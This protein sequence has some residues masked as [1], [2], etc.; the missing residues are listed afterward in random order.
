MNKTL[1]IESNN[2]SGKLLSDRNQKNAKISDTNLEEQNSHW[3]TNLNYGVK[4]EEGDQLSISS[5]QINLRGDP[6]QTIEFSA[7]RCSQYENP[8]Y[9]N[10]AQVEYAYYVT[11][12]HQFNMPLPLA[13][14]KI[15]T[16]RYWM[17]PTFG[18][19]AGE[20]THEEQEVT[21]PGET[22]SKN[23]WKNF[24]E[25][26]PCVAFE[27][28]MEKQCKYKYSKSEGFIGSFWNPINVDGGQ[29]PA[30]HTDWVPPAEAT[31][32][33]QR[34]TGLS[35]CGTNIT[36]PISNGPFNIAFP[37]NN[38]LYVCRDDHRG[39]W[40][41][42]KNSTGPNQKLNRVYYDDFMTDYT[43]LEADE[44]FYTPSALGNK[45]TTAFHQREGT[46]EDWKPVN[47]EPYVYEHSST[48]T[49]QNGDFAD[50][51]SGSYSQ[52]SHIKA[53]YLPYWSECRKGDPFIGPFVRLNKK[54]VA[55]V[56]DR[57]YKTIKTAGGRLLDKIYQA[58]DLDHIGFDYGRSEWSKPRAGHPGEYDNFGANIPN[59]KHWTWQVPDPGNTDACDGAWGEHYDSDNGRDLFYEN[60]LVGDMN[61]YQ[62]QINFNQFCFSNIFPMDFF[63]TNRHDVANFPANRPDFNDIMFGVN[64]EDPDFGGAGVYLSS[65]QVLEAPAGSYTPDSADPTTFLGVFGSKVVLTD[66]YIKCLDEQGYQKVYHDEEEP[67]NEKRHYNFPNCAPDGYWLPGDL[68]VDNVRLRGNQDRYVPCPILNRP[69]I[70]CTSGDDFTL[71]VTNIIAT[72][73][74][75]A[76]VKNSLYRAKEVDFGSNATMDE[77]TKNKDFF[78]SWVCK[79]DIG[80]TDDETTINVNC[81]EANSKFDALTN[82]WNVP[83]PY[84]ITSEYQNNTL[85]NN[86]MQSEQ[87]G[88]YWS[89]YNHYW[90][91]QNKQNVNPTRPPTQGGKDMGIKMRYNANQRQGREFNKLW[92]HTCW[93]ES[94]DPDSPQFNQTLPPY[95]LFSMT[96]S[97]GY[98]YSGTKYFKKGGIPKEF[99]PAD[100]NAVGVDEG[101]GL[102]AVFYKQERGD[103]HNGGLTMN[104]RGM[105]EPNASHPEVNK[106]YPERTNP[107]GTGGGDGNYG[108]DNHVP[109]YGENVFGDAKYSYQASKIPFLAFVVRKSETEAGKR[110]Y[111][112]RTL[113]VPQIGEYLGFSPAFSDGEYS[114]VISTQRVNPK[115]YNTIT[116]TLKAT[117]TKYTDAAQYG[118][119]LYY[120]IFDYYPYIHVGA[121]D[122]QIEFNA[123]SGRFE[124]SNLHTP[125][126]VGNGAWQEPSNQSNPEASQ[127]VMIINSK[128]SYISQLTMAGRF[129]YNA[130]GQ[131][132]N[133]PEHGIIS[134]PKTNLDELGFQPD[135]HNFA[136]GAG[137]PYP[138]MTRFNWGGNYVPNTSTGYGYW[139]NGVAGG[140]NCPIIPYGE[141]Y[142]ASGPNRIISAQSGIGIINLYAPYR[143]TDLNEFGNNPVSDSIILSPWQPQIFRETIF[144]KMGFSAEQMIPFYGLYNNDFN[145]SNYNKFLGAENTQI[146]PKQDNMVYPL[147]TNGYVTS[148][149]A[150]SAVTN[151]WLGYD[152][153]GD[154]FPVDVEM[155]ELLQ[156][157][158]IAPS[159]GGNTSTWL[160]D[161]PPAAQL[162]MFNLGGNSNSVSQ[163]VTVSSD[164]LI[165]AEL[166]RKYNFSYMVVHSNIIEQASNFIS[167]SNKM[168][169]I[170]AVGYLNRNYA[171]ADFFYSFD[172]DF[173]YTIDKTHILNNFEVELRLPNGQLARVDRNC[174]ILFKVTKAVKPPLQL[175]PPAPPTKKEIEDKNKK[176]GRYESSLV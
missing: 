63:S 32:K 126:Y 147:T 101:V 81:P 14:H 17:D 84:N 128:S 89:S 105:G 71:V 95:S 97:D 161:L 9:D 157:A 119:G 158:W 96:D 149:L 41:T 3:Q 175:K 159:W 142:Q 151:N 39:P 123:Q 160:K 44:G 1:I 46:A 55:D 79:L 137:A 38:R 117:N 150:F 12:R 155:N 127:E 140:D 13:T 37:N 64:Q 115:P 111:R 57:T 24:H 87:D 47:V 72:P 43:L 2:A 70:A 11:N 20:L 83:T 61:R 103:W 129:T 10:K 122:P 26:Y 131:E 73:Q 90:I 19:W 110:P 8:I 42:A 132:A 113:I 165:A 18:S 169:P 144:S 125:S 36:V 50:S 172:S 94:M 35:Y 114:Q 143:T 15:T 106:Y 136:A 4:L 98:T 88:G 6:S 170:P 67:D 65:G 148:T 112:E 91:S 60:L 75:I 167:G 80:I 146:L 141:L 120:N 121:L 53:G 108:R 48:W 92:V 166:P 174:S 124:I 58:N 5:V 85:W 162:Q 59:N 54:K 102:C 25:S 156:S 40:Q 139:E 153:M 76:K 22:D 30:A 7:D 130:P 52:I 99:L 145:R 109:G 104:D 56:T 34:R 134:I 86:G 107:G 138:T 176:E 100:G 68:N 173:V 66:S 171:S 16:P 21:E 27:G 28:V 133:G 93:D 77:R 49:S 45:L 164:A 163:N 62:A 69:I 154:I 23:P 168:I 152:T 51:S 135:I 29:A 82:K 118:V 33:D 116:D 74:A 31:D 78:K